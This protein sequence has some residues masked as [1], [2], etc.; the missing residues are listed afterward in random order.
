MRCCPKEPS[1]KLLRSIH[2]EARDVARAIAK[3]DAFE[4][5]CRERKCVEMLFAHLKRIL[6]LG[7]LRLRGPRG[8]LFQ[9]TL[10]ALAQNLRRL[11]KLLARP[12]PQP[13]SCAA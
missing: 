9:F 12:P 6:R 3:T 1:R 11:A 7:R 8:A 13:V 4:Q 2:E 10:A 5:S